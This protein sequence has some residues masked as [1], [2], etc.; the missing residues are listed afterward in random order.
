[1]ATYGVEIFGI[2]D[3]LGDRRDVRVEIEGVTTL[4]GLVSELRRCMPALEKR[5]ILSGEDRLLPQLWFNVNG[6]FYRDQ[7]DLVVSPRD[8]ILILSLAMGG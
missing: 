6:R 5:V 2:P 8:H 3:L 1:M 7:Y 4:A